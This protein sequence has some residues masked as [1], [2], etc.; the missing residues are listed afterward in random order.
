MSGSKAGAVRVER[1]EDSRVSI[2]NS[3]AHSTG[4]LPIK[5]QYSLASEIL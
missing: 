1:Q 2:T 4:D 5:E 3:S